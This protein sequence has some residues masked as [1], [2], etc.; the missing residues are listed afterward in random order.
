MNA[1]HEAKRPWRTARQKSIDWLHFRLIRFGF[2]HRGPVSSRLSLFKA[3]TPFWP[4]NPLFRL[5]IRLRIAVTQA[6]RT[7]PCTWL[8][9]IA[10]LLGQPQNSFLR[11]ELQR[12]CQTMDLHCS[13][14]SLRHPPV[15]VPGLSLP[16]KSKKFFWPS[17][18]VS[19]DT[20]CSSARSSPCDGRY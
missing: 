7:S 6:F 16:A 1:Q 2:V 17:K 9:G 10:C 5:Q 15:F 8:I 13:R 20:P 18:L 14:S 3:W 11:H 12:F 4:S 19:L